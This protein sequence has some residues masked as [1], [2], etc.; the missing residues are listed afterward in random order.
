MHI[1]FV[2]ANN[3]S[4]PYFNWFAEEAHRKG[5]HTF[6]F[7]AMTAEKP[8][9]PDDVGKYNW[10]GH[11][12]RFNCKHRRTHMVLAVWKLFWLFRKIKPDVVSTH[13][14]DDSVPALLA[15]RIAGVKIRAITKGDTSF[16]YRHTPQWVKFD[17]FNNC[18]ANLVISPSAE[19]REFII[20]IEK[21]LASKIHL[22]H[23]GIPVEPYCN[24]DLNYSEVTVL[25][26]NLKG[27]FV[28]GTVSRFIEWK[29]YTSIVKVIEKL[30]PLYPDMVFV[31][32]GEGGQKPYIKQ[33]ISEKGLNDVV[34]F[35]ERI[36]NDQM[37]YFYKNLDVY[38]HAANMEPF[39]FTIAEA[40][41]SGL[42]VVSM[43]TGAARDAIQHTI[44]GWLGKYED[45]DSL[46]E[47]VE[48]FYHNRVGKPWLMAR[49]TAQ[50]LFD[51]R[52][53]F[54]SYTGLF[55]SYY[56]KKAALP[57]IVFV[58]AN[59]SSVPYFTLFMERAKKLGAFRFSFVAMT[60]ERPEMIDEARSYGFDG[61]WIPFNN[62]HRRWQMIWAV[63]RLM[64]L[65]RKI[66]PDVVHT[67][68]FDDSVPALLAARVSGIPARVITKQDTSFH[69][70]YAKRWVGF[71]R[72]N[73]RNATHVVAVSKEAYDFVIDKEKCDKRKIS[74][75]HHGIDIDRFS[76]PDPTLVDEFKTKYQLHNCLVIGTVARFIEWKKFNIV[77]ETAAIVAKSVP[78]SR[79]LLIGQGDLMPEILDLIHKKGL[80]KNVILTG[81]IEKGLMQH[82]YGAMDQYLH[83]AHMEPFGFVIAEAMVAGL[84]VVSTP[85]GAA[86]DAIIQKQN[87]WLGE[88]DNP[89]SLAD[90]ILYFYHNRPVL[91]WKEAQQTANKMFN[92]ERMFDDY[93]NLYTNA[94]RKDETIT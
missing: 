30:A 55:E 94:L 1:V 61:Y 57:H 81:F 87:G 88:Y 24:F 46:V 5:A 51:F 92:F 75:I 33:L 34:I 43:P 10:K 35:A 78:E 74:M 26:Y 89:Q 37:P 49:E 82:V 45:T 56:T 21:C 38:L 28:V 13:L 93:I 12:I 86:R 42:P 7:V 20:D 63:P 71:D 17:R 84:P 62:E 70:F 19:G 32:L 50:R 6:S 3:S 59:N 22:I 69:F 85:T 80:E 2:M 16:H 76:I 83:A 25:P 9:M 52:K 36:E 11:W 58:I 47:G 48:F 68:L 15:A 64:K 67:H 40:M 54:D 53:M 14:F 90:G 29:G 79:F 8:K 27:K 60:R 31:F 41:M 65:F 39:G 72:F 4:V 73:N 23:H 66:H 77:V 44:N 18:N 91:P